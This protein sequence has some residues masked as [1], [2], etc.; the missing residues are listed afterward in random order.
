MKR[1]LQ[2]SSSTRL[3]AGLEYHPKAEVRAW[4]RRAL[5]MDGILKA[6]AA[7]GGIGLS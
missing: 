2:L 4:V 1:F 7:A 5:V 6:R 3:V